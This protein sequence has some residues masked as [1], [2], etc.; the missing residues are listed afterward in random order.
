MNTSRLFLILVILIPIFACKHPSPAGSNPALY[1]SDIRPLTEAI[2]K[3]TSRAELWFKR[4]L[5]LHR[6]KLD[7]LALED[8]YKAA[9]LDTNRAVY[10]STIGDL[11]F[12]HKDV[13]TAVIWLQRALRHD[14]N[15]IKA[16][17]K[18]AKM[19]LFTKDYPTSIAEINTVLRQDAYN[20][21]GYFLKGV[22]YKELKD[23]NKAISSFQTVINVAPDYREAAIQLGLIYS[24]QGNELGLQYLNN[25]FRLDTTD[26]FP[27]YARGM[28]YQ[29]KKDFAQAKR[30]YSNCIMHD[31]QYGDAYFANGFI[32]LQEDSLEKARRQFDLVTRIHP[33][34]PAA[35][36]NRGLCSELLKDTKTAAD[37]YRQAL[38]FD[39]D[40]KAAIEGLKRVGG[41]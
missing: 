14:P 7:S 18:V 15:D 13:N 31:A 19:M 28:Y 38:I 32:L 25:A 17:L 12:E 21:E 41:K 24:A 36:Y 11:L 4:G 20:P 33:T 2:A 9:H 27:L 6:Q 35:Y 10:A 22:V 26:V 30:E 3:D 40:Y 1:S 29:Q 16:H 37:D 23:T 8:F 39:K 34:D 5:A